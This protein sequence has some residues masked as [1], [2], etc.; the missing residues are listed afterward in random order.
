MSALACLQQ[1]YVPLPTSPPPYVYYQHVDVVKASV[2]RSYGT[3][4]DRWFAV[5]GARS[6][7]GSAATRE[8]D[9]D[10][11]NRLHKLPGYMSEWALQRAPKAHCL[12]S[13]SHSQPT[14]AC[15]HT[16]QAVF[17]CDA[18]AV[19][20][21]PLQLQARASQDSTPP[22]LGCSWAALRYP[23]QGINGAAACPLPLSFTLLVGHLCT[24]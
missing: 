8:A 21:L 20:H 4:L 15:F 17:Q 13:R 3:S 10:S 1:F 24:I 6:E 2:L 23:P 5:W 14:S 9:G 11:P 7:S 16:W 12:P 19:L 22:A 18:P